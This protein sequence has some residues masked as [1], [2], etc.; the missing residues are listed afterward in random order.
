[1]NRRAFVTLCIAI[2]VAMLGMG[3]V[4]P[5]LPIYANKMGA[6]GT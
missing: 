3:I 2:F 1:M 4:S 5:L 6:T